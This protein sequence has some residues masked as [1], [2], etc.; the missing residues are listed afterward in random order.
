MLLRK[1]VFFSV[2]SCAVF[3]M[4]CE[5]KTISNAPPPDTSVKQPNIKV[6]KGKEMK[7]ELP[8]APPPP[9]PPGPPPK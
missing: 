5:K 2:L 6:P 4:G 9:A 3:L 7:R 1:S 8:M